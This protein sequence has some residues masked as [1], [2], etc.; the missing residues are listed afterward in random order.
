MLSAFSTPL[1]G[2]E[3]KSDKKVEHRHMLESMN[4]T[5]NSR[6]SYYWLRSA[7]VYVSVLIKL[8]MELGRTAEAGVEVGVAWYI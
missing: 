8:I 1:H 3:V 4:I 5:W 7:V 2:A 6:V